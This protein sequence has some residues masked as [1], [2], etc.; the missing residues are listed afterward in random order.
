MLKVIRI[1]VV[2]IC[3][4]LI[5][6]I[7]SLYSL[8]NFKNP[9][10]VAVFAHWFARLHPLFGLKVEYRYP[11]GADKFERCIYVGNH[12]NNYDMVTISHMVMPRTVSVGKKASFGFRF[13]ASFTGLPVIFLLIEKIAVKPTTQ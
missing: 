5:C 13:L 8:I 1:I 6:V 7:G 4:I 9:N 11:Q 12:Q 2:A 10:N 3:C